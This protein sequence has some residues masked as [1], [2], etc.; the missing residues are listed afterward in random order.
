MITKELQQ[1]R[2]E[3]NFKHFYIKVSSFIPSLKDF[4]ARKLN[5]A[6]DLGVIDKNFFNPNDI[7]DDVYLD[8]FE[9]FNNKIAKKDLRR[10]LFEKSV[11][12]IDEITI[13]GHQ[14]ENNINIG[15]ILKEE[16]QTMDERY[17]T[18]GDGDFILY[19]ELDD[20][21]YHQNDFKP[22]HIILDQSIEKLITSKLNLEDLT[23]QSA[24]KRKLLGSLFFKMPPRSKA[25]IELYV[26]ANQSVSEISEILIIEELMVKKV[27]NKVKEKFSLIL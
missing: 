14:F 10:M 24:K 12:K 5:I 2:L 7:L 22:K 3:N 21:S 23:L 1:L 4:I 13:L 25:I 17:T 19:E 20:I 11:E 8:V 27:V 18:D 16:L 9:N 15:E 6:E 26:F